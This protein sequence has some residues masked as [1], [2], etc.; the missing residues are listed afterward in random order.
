MTDIMI[1][2]NNG[3]MLIHLNEFYSC[4]NITKVKK[5]VKLIRQSYT[6]ECE[7]QMKE[8][9]Q[10][11]IKALDDLIAITKNK[12]ILN[13]EAEKEYKKYVKYKEFY[14]KVLTIVE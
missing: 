3:R 4:R 13:K 14:T 7:E 1:K 11:R 2:Y 10:R 12:A 8:Y 6:P 5:L 9:A